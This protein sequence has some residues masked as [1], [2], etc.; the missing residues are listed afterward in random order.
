METTRKNLQ[1]LIKKY[2]EYL[3][4]YKDLNNG[5]IKGCTPFNVFYWRFTYY[6]KYE[7]PSRIGTDRF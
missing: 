7:D 3:K 2:T 4:L 5:S 1:K 6:I